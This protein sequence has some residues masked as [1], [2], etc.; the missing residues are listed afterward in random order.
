MCAC[1]AAVFIAA[2]AANFAPTAAFFSASSRARN[3]T[4]HAGAV[5]GARRSESTVIN[6]FCHNYAALA[7]G[8]RGKR[9]VAASRAEFDLKVLTAA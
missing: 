7:T 4:I 1:F 3:S 2:F 8:N 6:M 9:C 5:L